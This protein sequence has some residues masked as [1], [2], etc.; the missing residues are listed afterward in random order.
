MRIRYWSSDVCSSDLDFTRRHVRE[1]KRLS[2]GTEAGAV[3]AADARNQ[4]LDRPVAGKAIETAI[5]F[6]GA[7]LV[8]AAAEKIAVP[9][10][11]PIVE[12]RVRQFRFHLG[13]G[14]VAAGDGIEEPEAFG[15]PD[16]IA[17]SLTEADRTYAI[18]HA[19]SAKPS[20]SAITP[21]LSLVDI[22]PD[23]FTRPIV[24]YQIGRAHV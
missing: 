21:Q 16:D 22:D 24:P 9:V 13:D 1:V 18:G 8:D 12:A 5:G 10:A 2:I 20:A 11:S 19:V 15:K 17:R 14:F 7:A 3:G 6:S 23:E 4:R